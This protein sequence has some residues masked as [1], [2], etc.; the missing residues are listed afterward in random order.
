V[1]Y[2]RWAADPVAAERAAVEAGVVT[3]AVDVGTVVVGA[4]VV[5]AVLTVAV[6][7]DTGYQV[8]G[9]GPEPGSATDTVGDAAAVAGTTGTVPR[10][11]GAAGVLLGTA[12]CAT[13]ASLYGDPSKAFAPGPAPPTVPAS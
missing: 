3:A 11:V 8:S 13:S 5:G 7:V 9:A 12:D 6:E 10:A 4:A 2:I 1:P